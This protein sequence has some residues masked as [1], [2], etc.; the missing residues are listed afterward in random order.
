MNTRD[1]AIDGAIE[2]YVIE[3]K[4]MEI[5]PNEP[6]KSNERREHKNWWGVSH[7]AGAGF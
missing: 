5:R 7:R 3:G 2:G 4:A 6:E 1:V